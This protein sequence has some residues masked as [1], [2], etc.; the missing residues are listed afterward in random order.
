VT[1]EHVVLSFHEFYGISVSPVRASELAEELT[2]LLGAL[3]NLETRANFDG[4]PDE[5][6]SAL[7]LVSRLKIGNEE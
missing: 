1:P 3:T 4:W 6:L 2:K 5:F 7:A